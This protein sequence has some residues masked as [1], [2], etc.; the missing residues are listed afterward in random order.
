VS[1][2]RLAAALPSSSHPSPISWA[3][4][5]DPL[6]TS[7]SG[8]AG[9]GV[10]KFGRV[11]VLQEDEGGSLFNFWNLASSWQIADWKHGFYP[12]VPAGLNNRR[13]DSDYCSEGEQIVKGNIRKPRGCL[14]DFW[15]HYSIN[16]FFCVYCPEERG[17]SNSRNLISIICTI[18]P[19]V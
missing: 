13:L 6:A 10:G 9:R 12:Q 8:A 3:P 4:S 2:P 11:R 16:H 15:I 7:C 14:V 19:I 18:V 1:T 17:F 5:L